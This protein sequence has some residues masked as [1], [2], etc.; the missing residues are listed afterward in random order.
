MVHLHR[1]QLGFKLKLVCVVWATKALLP[2]SHYRS[3]GSFSF[4]HRML[5]P[6]GLL[7]KLEISWKREL[8]EK[9]KTKDG[10]YKQVSSKCQVLGSAGD[11]RK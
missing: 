4:H 7:P 6:S 10:G 3:T 11:T 2:G 9:C 5:C 8:K 1:C